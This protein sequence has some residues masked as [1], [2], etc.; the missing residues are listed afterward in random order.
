MGHFIHI[1][2]SLS[3]KSP[4]LIDKERDSY[5][6]ANIQFRQTIFRKA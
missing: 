1:I 4:Y 6:K 5:K 3:H 2:D